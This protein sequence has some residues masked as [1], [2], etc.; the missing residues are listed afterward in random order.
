MNQYSHFAIDEAAIVRD[1]TATD[2][3]QWRLLRRLCLPERYNEPQGG[4]IK[5]AVVVDVETTG[6]STENDDVI[7]LAILPFDYEAETGR[8]LTVH[9]SQ[10]FEGLREPSVPISEDASLITGITDDMVA[11]KSIDD[12]VVAPPSR[13]KTPALGSQLPPLPTFKCQCPLFA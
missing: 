3:T 2:P 10:A 9:N 11:G 8:I 1:Q 13:S 4:L 6:L 5:R 7:Q 12:S